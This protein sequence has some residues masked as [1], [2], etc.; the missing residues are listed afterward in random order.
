MGQDY[1]TVNMCQ[2]YTSSTYSALKANAFGVITQNNGHYDVQSHSR[3]SILVR[4]ESPM[5]LSISE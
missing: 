1:I 4:I 5:R 2:D 3:S